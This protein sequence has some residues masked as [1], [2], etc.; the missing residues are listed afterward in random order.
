MKSIV[1]F[2]K[3]FL[4]MLFFTCFLFQKSNSQCLLIP[5]SLDQRVNQSTLIVEG[6]VKNERS[7]WDESHY[8]IYTIYTVE[9]TRIFKGNPI[10]SSIEVV[11]QGGQIDNKLEIVTNTIKTENGEAGVFTLIPTNDPVKTDKP[12]Y[13]CYAATQGFLKYDGVDRSAS[14]VFDKYVSVENDLYPR[15]ESKLGKSRATSFSL[16]WEKIIGG[17][18]KQ[19]SH[20]H[21]N[22]EIN[23]QRPEGTEGTTAITGF[24]PTSI[25]AGTSSSIVISG[26]GFGA[27]Q[28]TSTVQFKNANDGGSTYISPLANQYLSWSD[29]SITVVVPTQAGTGT[30]RVVTT[31]N[32]FT[33]SSNLT[34]SYNITNFTY[35]TNSTAYFAKLKNDNSAGGYSFSYFTDFAASTNAVTYFEKSKDDWICASGVNWAIGSITAID[36]IA[37]DG[38]NVVRF[39]N[40]SELSTGVLGQT[41]SRYSGCVSGT[42]YYWHLE[43]VDM[44]YDDGASFYYGTGTTFTG[45]YDFYSIVLHEMGHAHQIG[46]SIS[47]P[48]LMHW[49]I[50]TNQV[51]RTINTNDV[52]AASYTLTTTA[53]GTFCSGS[54][55]IQTLVCN[56]PTVTL[57]SSTSNIAETGGSATI[58]ATLSG[59]YKSD[60][61][62]TLAKSGTATDVT[63]YSL[64]STTITIPYGSLS[65]SVTLTSVNDVIDET[66]ETVIIDIASVTNGTENGTQQQTVTIT[67]DDAAPTVT[68]T[69]GTITIAETGGSTSVTATLSAVSG[70]PV[71]VTLGLTGTATITT[72]YT[73]GTTISIPAGST[74]ASITLASVGDV[75]DEANETVIADITAVT[76]GTENGT[77]QQTVTITDDDAAPTV[78]LTT[79]TA[80]IAE[81]GGSTNVTATLSA[82]S[83]Q[84]VTVT[85]GL[86]GTATITTDYTLGT[87]IS[88]PAGSTSASIT[89][90]SIS[91]VLDEPNETVII[92]ITSV[93]N[94]TENGTQQ[95]TVT[96]TDDDAAPTVTLSSTASSIAELGG[97]TNVT[98]TLSAVSGLAVTINLATSGTATSGAD[99]TL[100]A[101]SIVIPVGSNSGSVTITG[102]TDALTEGNE[103]AIIDISTVVNGTESTVQQ[104][105]ITIVDNVSVLPIRFQSFTATM[106]NCNANL[107][108]ATA[109]EQNNNHFEIEWSVDGLVWTNIANI[110][111]KGNSSGTQTYQSMHANPAVGNNYY[112]IQQIDND[113]KTTYS[114]VVTVKSNCND[115]K[116][117]VSPN[118]FINQV[119]VNGIANASTIKILDAKG[120][121]ISLTS[122]VINTSTINTTSLAKGNY[123][124]LVIDDKGNN[125]TFSLVK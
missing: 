19:N 13:E 10:G 2:K 59:R 57:T 109:F 45:Q 22:N 93:T 6:I 52:S 43:E 99:Y 107:T 36:V 24:S 78:S 117:V 124:L 92:D 49:S 77:Q 29:N 44:A 26:S 122:K 104:K 115:V 53:A 72:D 69:T 118:P 106:N 100:S 31:A 95:K 17:K 70:Q 84:A 79:G 98:V 23:Q 55:A 11:S 66:N 75:I 4:I 12:L 9:L 116:I 103:T 28:G 20:N 81:S 68:L 96:I 1:H 90:A 51:K 102:I 64:S 82:V 37:S 56:P 111:S 94:G 110:L 97:S 89:L 121:V 33:S 112:R 27:T 39:D 16:Q 85:L 83:G 105:T 48:D 74:S 46:H 50:S 101:T 71:T 47:S 58:T 80:T 86:T 5:I 25:T 108:F 87:T 32:T 15:L 113:G 120:S 63:D 41:T 18:T 76:N 30:V 40:G 35:A 7:I 65:G 119:T 125:Q 34:V 60:V 62:V 114:N 14:G 88:I 38:V 8:N 67:D 61:T 21:L 73:L 123:Y 3:R 54:T 91:D 42:N